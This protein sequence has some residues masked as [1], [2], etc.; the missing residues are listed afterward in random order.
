MLYFKILN[1]L[2]LLWDFS[3]LMYIKNSPK[4]EVIYNISKNTLTRIFI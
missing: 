1:D 4:S 3:M 2:E